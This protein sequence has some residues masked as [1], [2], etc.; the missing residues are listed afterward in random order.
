M[1]SVAGIPK[2]RCRTTIPERILETLSGAALYRGTRGLTR[3][4]AGEPAC[5][6]AVLPGIGTG[7]IAR[8]R[9]TAYQLDEARPLQ[10]ASRSGIAGYGAFIYRTLPYAIGSPVSG[11]I[12]ERGNGLKPRSARCLRHH[13]RPKKGSVGCAPLVKDGPRPFPFL[14]EVH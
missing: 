3:P 14:F 8:V 10:R 6:D 7:R 11:L 13:N 5:G 12:R 9:S 1:M 2:N 4:P